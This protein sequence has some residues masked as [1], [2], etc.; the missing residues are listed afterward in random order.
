VKI[1]LPRLQDAKAE[2][3]QQAEA[4]PPLSSDSEVALVVEDSEDV[5]AS[6]FNLR[7]LGYTVLEARDA[8]AL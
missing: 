5:R 6:V 2:T 4:Q 3:L 7:E 1:Y 8:E